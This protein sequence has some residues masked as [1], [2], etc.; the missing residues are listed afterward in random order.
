MQVVALPKVFFLVSLPSAAYSFYGT[1]V[2]F[3]SMHVETNANLQSAVMRLATVFR[4]VR[5]L[6]SKGH[7]SVLHQ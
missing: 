3:I 4:P 5:N 7:E 2:P 6:I 1:V